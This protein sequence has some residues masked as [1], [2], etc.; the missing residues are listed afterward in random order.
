MVERYLN[1]VHT[2]QEPI[3]ALAYPL[4]TSTEQNKRK[5]KINSITHTITFDILYTQ[6][7]YVG[8]I[9]KKEYIN[10]SNRWYY[11]HIVPCANEGVQNNKRFTC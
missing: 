1:R 5:G 4:Y 3:L 11:A 9:T 10:V 8:D 6:Y 7:I 2:H